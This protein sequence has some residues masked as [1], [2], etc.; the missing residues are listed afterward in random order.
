MTTP[1]TCA[2]SHRSTA[3]K[4]PGEVAFQAEQMK[5]S[6]YS[7]LE[8]K[9]HFVPVVMETS[10]VLGLEAREF[11]HN[12]GHRIA[13]VSIEVDSLQFLIQRIW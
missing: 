1:D 3:V 2:P 7:A 5:H 12:L 10:G 9:F 11:L 6:K 8:A 4:G 13:C